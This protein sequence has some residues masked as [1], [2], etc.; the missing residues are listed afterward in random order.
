ME[1]SEQG[2]AAI[3]G[4]NLGVDLGTTFV[5][6]AIARSGQIEM[7][8]LGDRSVV[9]PSMVYLREDGQLITGE[10]ASR[11]SISNPQRVSREFKRRLGDPTPV[12]LGGQPHAVTGLLASV[13]SDVVASV[14]EMEG[15]QSGRVMLTH[16]ANWG[17]F[18]RGLFEEVPALAGLSESRLISEP[19]AAAAHYAAAR[20][21]DDGGVVAVYDLGGGTFDATVLAK[22]GERV[23]ILGIPEGIERLGGVD[24][25]EAIMAHVNAFSGGLL[26][27]LDLGDNKVT[28]ALA[29]L[30]QDC[31]LAKETLSMDTETTV[32][33]F[34]PGR[35]LEVPLTR[36][37]FEDLVRASIESTIGALERT[38]RSAGVAPD[39]LGS[40]LLIG[41]SSRIPLIARM[42]AEQLGCPTVVDTHPKHAVALGAAAL[43]GGAANGAS[44]SLSKQRDDSYSTKDANNRETAKPV[45]SSLSVDSNQDSEWLGPKVPEPP[46]PNNDP[47]AWL[48]VDTRKRRPSRIPK[49]ALALLVLVVIV[50]VVAIAWPSQPDTPPAAQPTPSS[51]PPSPMPA[52][53]PV[54]AMAS[55]RFLGLVNAG[56]SPDFAAPTPDG[57]RL[58]VTN[59]NA[60]T[61]TAVDTTTNSAV[62]TIAVPNGPPHYIM[63]SPDGR[64]VYV[65]VFSNPDTVASIDVIDAATNKIVQTIPMP[66]KPMQPNSAAMTSMKPLLPFV[67]AFNA[68]GS[69]LWVPNHNAGTI[70]VLNPLSGAV[71]REFPV[72]ANPHWIRFSPD[73]SRVYTANHESNVVTLVDAR[74]FHVIT[75]IGVGDSPHSVAVHPTLPL[76]VDCNYGA[77]S[78]TFIDTNTRIGDVAVGQQPQDVEFSPDGQFLYV[79]NDGDNSVSVIN[80]ATRQQTAKLQTGH[81][82]TTIAVLPDGKHAYV[83]N[84][85]DGNLTLLQV[86]Q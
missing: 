28:V 81:S 33:V 5:A 73:H 4:Y 12:I 23:E 16:P 82:P 54:H 49:L 58:Y 86:G 67:G 55:P 84:L 69:Q 70:T 9:V 42:V 68:D 39:E 3:M 85:D 76:A 64:R 56:P 72:P 15:A 14:A 40:V 47:N 60:G 74:D 75:K 78:V 8:T 80:V 31:V 13:L 29:R 34:L 46:A 17:P 37:E 48:T 63:I 25:D 43:A 57:R 62:A 41:G 30:R 26:D 83:S 18:R 35:H 36:A 19:E 65:T 45:S 32:P 20:R 6:V 52:P 10:P 61:V 2:V 11:R 51:S 44:V 53:Q 7:A 24:F 38:L 22:R 27:E 21:L 71:I 79:V 50:V 77:A 1:R 66:P 59:V